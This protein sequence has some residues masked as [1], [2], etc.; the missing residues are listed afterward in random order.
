MCFLIL[1]K[2]C[3]GSILLDG[4]AGGP[5]EKEAPPNLTLRP[6]AFQAINEIQ[7]LVTK[8]CGSVVSCSDIAALSAR[9]S[10]YLVSRKFKIH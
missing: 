6:A 9:D 3:D 2:G 1:V 10:V 5:S 7:A 8:A 4:S